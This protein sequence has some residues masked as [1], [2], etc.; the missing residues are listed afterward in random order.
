L[1]TMVRALAALAF[2]ALAAVLA[3]Q[4]GVIRLPLPPSG[5]AGDAGETRAPPTDALATAA[6]EKLR[7][8]RAG[9]AEQVALGGAE[10]ESL[11]ILRHESLIPPVVD[12]PQVDLNAALLHLR[13]R[14]AAERIPNVGDLGVVLSMLPDTVDVEMAG[15]LASVSDGRAALR[16]E[17]IRIGAVPVPQRLIAPILARLGREDMPGL[18]PDALRIP[19][20]PGVGSAYVRADSL[21]LS[22]RSDAAESGARSA[23]VPPS[24]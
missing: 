21:V 14:I 7:R 2:L 5:T 4:Q 11:L 6:E 20:P 19:L 17:T 1:R 23:P 10:L 13:G 15:R 24:R 12:D 16:V 22:R 3:F 18:H 9:E 8:L